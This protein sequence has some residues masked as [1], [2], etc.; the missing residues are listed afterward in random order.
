MNPRASAFWARFKAHRWAS[1]VVVLLTLAVGILIGTVISYGVRGQ[2]KNN[3][4]DAT[5]LS[6]PPP[7]PKQLSSAFAQI[8]KQLEPA[9]V[10]INTAAA[11]DLRPLPLGGRIAQLRPIRAGLRFPAAPPKFARYDI[12]EFVY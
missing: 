10:N 3:S 1:T 11:A 7:N 2:D 5:P 4:A 6:V 12:R 9:V 8:A